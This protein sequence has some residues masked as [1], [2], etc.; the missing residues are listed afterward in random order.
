ERA[1]KLNSS[2][3]FLTATPR[4]EQR[5]QMAKKQLTY[6]FVP[7]RYH[8]QLLPIPK[9]QQAKPLEKCLTQQTL[10][11]QFI[12][13]LQNRQVPS[14]QLLIFVPTVHQTHQLQKLLQRTYA[15]ALSE[16][17][18]IESVHAEDSN[19]E[20]K[21]IDFRKRL[22]HVLTSTVILVLGDTLLASNVM[23]LDSHHQIIEEAEL[24]QISER[25]GKNKE[26]IT[27]ENTFIQ[28]DNS[29]SMVK[30]K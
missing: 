24:V 28:N 2:L 27:G 8:Q 20:K 21:I 30:A 3:I 26:E 18:Y 5:K 10:P 25:A 7:L 29:N 4:E 22:I 14:R 6:V 19:R 9:F 13:W 11:K 23:V 17:I 1:K 15:L 16:N 12:H